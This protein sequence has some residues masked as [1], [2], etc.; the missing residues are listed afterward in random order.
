[1]AILIAVA[2][3]LKPV[4][5]ATP[6]EKTL[7]ESACEL[8]DQ[9][10]AR[11]LAL[12]E[13]VLKQAPHH[14]GALMLA[15]EAAA[16]MHDDALALHYFEQAIQHGG[17]RSVDALHLAG[18]RALRIGRV[19]DSERYLRRALELDP[20]HLD[21]NRHLAELL[22]LQGRTWESLPHV[23]ALLRAGVFTI[24]NLQ[25][26]SDTDMVW[27]SDQD[28][29]ARCLKA[30]PHDPLP[31]LCRARV[32]LLFN[33]KQHASDLLHRV[34]AAHPDQMQA[35]AHLGRLLLD[36]KSDFLGWHSRLGQDAD[37]H[38]EIWFLRGMW[39][40]QNGQTR[41]A[42]RC[43]WEALCLH[44]DHSAA[45]HQL[46]SALARLGQ[47]EESRLLAERARQLDQVKLMQS[48]FDEREDFVRKVA[49]KLESLGRYWEAAGYYYVAWSADPRRTWATQGML[50]LHGRIHGA[51]RCDE[52]EMFVRSLDL[53]SEPLPQWNDVPAPGPSS[54]SS[55]QDVRVAFEDVAE[56][57]GLKFQYNNGAD[58]TGKRVYTFEYS[59]G[60]VGVLD[61][62]A[63][64]YPDLYLSQGCSWPVRADASADPDRLFR[65]RGDGVFEDVTLQTGLGDLGLSQGVTVGDINSD[66]FPDL[67]VANI[68]VGRLYLNNGDGTYRDVTEEAGVG[69]ESWASSCVLADF[70]QDALPDLYV[71]TYLTMKSIEHQ[72]E[73]SNRPVQCG[74]VGLDAEV[75]RLFLN[76]GDGRFRDV[77]Q[78]S[79]IVLPDGK[80][81]G[82]VA[83]DFDGS[84]RLGLFIANDTTANYFLVNQTAKP[85]DSI[86]FHDESAFRGVACD[87]MGRTQACMGVAA[88][89][90]NHDGRLDLLV[91][92]FLKEANALYLQQ[93]GG[94]FADQIKQA[95]LY[96][97][98]FNH[99]GWGTQFLDAE[100]DGAPDFAVANGH[101][102]DYTSEG[103][104][105]RMP[106]QFF[107]G[108]GK[109]EFAE[110]APSQ[111]GA[112]FQSPWLG[113]AMARLDWNRDGL[114]DLC[115]THVDRPV[116][117]VTNRTRN[118]GRHLKLHLRAVTTARDAI[119]AVVRVTTDEQTQMRQLTAGDGFYASNERVLVFG[120]GDR[121]SAAD[122]EITWPSGVTQKFRDV[123]ADSE[124]I[125]VE[126]SHGP[127]RVSQGL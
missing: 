55:E 109:G 8:S 68:G 4:Y 77:T 60:G 15:G 44:P 79:G 120:L 58:P 103:M 37:H 2:L 17:E 7:W 72:C 82:V 45:T 53:S 99:M 26:L 85:G 76:L 96:D 5:T 52:W 54:S 73:T 118:P 20:S 49:E 22:Q 41:A 112:Y 124:W 115:I 32:A 125:L 47:S 34:T 67:Y 50:R 113:R 116:A 10:Y 70:N 14:H 27:R 127:F 33:S 56:A 121:A 31:L 59:G 87:E 107:R 28:F 93:E 104:P 88:G 35:Q 97:A 61:Y 39:A 126:N 105:Y 3:V 25:E 11:S 42:A 6:H 111:L 122:I 43:F 12:A 9:R 90:A 48:Q 24:M 83:A 62:D 69:F 108:V 65:N 78:E 64:G 30:A 51:S 119:G 86:R 91:T 16:A 101:I 81:L 66:G 23:F 13:S 98:S 89:D 40:R 80:G 75:D 46:A 106:A 63:D 1:M 19:S 110:V 29:E 102:N 36:S 117:L 57:V 18:E 21:A 38:P 114:E 94:M 123:A 92:N 71:V 74:P 100:L 84:H 95:R